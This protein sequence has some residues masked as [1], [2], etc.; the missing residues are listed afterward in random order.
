[1]K[2]NNFGRTSNQSNNNYTNNNNQQQDFKQAYE[3]YSKMSEND[4]MN[5]MFEM[6]R[7]SKQNGELDNQ[8]IEQFYQSASL[9]FDENQRKKLRSLL[10]MLKD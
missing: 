2:K 7:A 9:M 10:D 1:M 8:K 5:Q 3:Q 4:L 6:A